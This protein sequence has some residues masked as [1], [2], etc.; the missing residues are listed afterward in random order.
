MTAPITAPIRA[1]ISGP[2][3]L[4]SYW[5]SSA[6]YRVRLA[7][8]WKRIDYEV[9]PIDLRRA[10]QGAADF[11]ARNPQAL[12]PL[13][14]TGAAALSQ[15][16]AIIEYLD[17]VCPEPPLLPRDA[18]GR[19][20]VRAAAQIIACD[21]HPIANLRVLQFLKISMAHSQAEIDTWARHWIAAGLAALEAFAADHG[22]RCLYGDQVTMADFC[23]IPQLYNARRV[24]SDLARYPR[25]QAIAASLEAEPRL[26]AAA[27]AA[28][29]DAD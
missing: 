22:G 28:Q 3:R 20:R 25:L 4:C 6:S 2:L 17:E 11:R 9:I 8:A 5:R 23:L 16:L 13:L 1:P 10:E 27:P 29:P 21:V 18:I 14:E 7:L 15:S 19:A 24:D 26:Q 12:V